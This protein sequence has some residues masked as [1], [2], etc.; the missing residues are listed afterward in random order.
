MS[1]VIV[2]GNGFD[3][4]LGWRTSYRDFYESKKGWEHFK[5]DEDDLFQYIIKHV[6]ENWYDFERTLHD[7]CVAKSKEG[8]SPEIIEK[9]INTYAAL[10]VELYNFIQ[11]RSKEPIKKN[12]FAYKL[13]SKCV[14]LSNRNNRSIEAIPRFFTFNYTALNEVAEQIEKETH[15]SY[16]PVH[17]TLAGNNII[18]GFQDDMSIR[19][20]YRRMQKSYDNRYSPS[21]LLD[22]LIDATNVIFFGMSMGCIDEIYFKGMFEK[23]CVIGGSRE[24]MKKNIT[25]IT[26][27]ETTKR[28]IKDNLQDAGIS[29]QILYNTNDV[30]FILTSDEDKTK[31]NMNFYQLLNRL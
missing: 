27:N 11:A 17:G 8:F 18:F 6:A 21:G 4:D 2:I 16:I 25:F 5:T 9:D 10:K 20:E 30:T 1:T 19:K 24:R 23:I 14:E 12:S 3:I 13:L 15:F 22:A 26:K 28:E 31:Q 29:M 7:Y